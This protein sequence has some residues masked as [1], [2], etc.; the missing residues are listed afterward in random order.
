[1]LFVGGVLGFIGYVMLLTAA[2][3]RS[4]PWFLGCLLV[5]F[6]ALVFVALNFRTAGKPFAILLIGTVFSAIGCD[7]AGILFD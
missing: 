2:H 6:A 3:R 1:M 4:I 7:M 5:P